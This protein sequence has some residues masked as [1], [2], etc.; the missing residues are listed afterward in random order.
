[1][2]VWLASFPRSGNTLLRIALN[3]LY[4][5]RTSTVYDVD[6]VAQR[7][8]PDLVGFADRSETFKAMRAT[9]QAHFVKTHR[10]RDDDVDDADGAIC[11]VRDG[12]DALVS[13]ARQ[14]CEVN[15]C[16]YEDELRS[17]VTRPDT[18]G[19][20]Q[21]GRNV[22]SWLVPG[23]PQRV[24]LRF[25]DLIHAPGD[26]VTAATALVAPGLVPERDAVIPSFA[27]LHAID[28]RF[29]RRGITGTHN[30]ELPADLHQAFWDQPDNRAAME[31]LRYR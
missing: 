21:W 29:F 19:A 16:R 28:D 3:R 2:I 14:R 15:G 5:V 12:R 9:K 26:M 23:A 20:G 1:V 22:S 10:P 31:L 4:G 8:G 25:E 11:L 18:R 6:G 7:L 30:D 13:W 17:L 24:A 27:D